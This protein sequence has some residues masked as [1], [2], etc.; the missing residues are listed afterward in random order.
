MPAY[1]PSTSTAK[2]HDDPSAQPFGIVSVTNRRASSCVYGSGT[3]VH[4][5]LT[6]SWHCS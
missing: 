5:W 6:G 4:C 2:P 1:R 3:V